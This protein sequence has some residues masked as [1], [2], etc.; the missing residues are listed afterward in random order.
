M[1]VPAKNFRAWLR[2]WAVG[3]N[4]QQSAGGSYVFTAEDVKKIVAAWNATH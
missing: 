4:F 2:K 3:R 1:G